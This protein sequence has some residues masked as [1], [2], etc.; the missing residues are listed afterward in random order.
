MCKNHCKNQ[1]PPNFRFFLSIKSVNS[2]QKRLPETIIPTET[3]GL[4]GTW[5]SFLGF[6]YVGP[7]GFRPLVCFFG[8]VF[9][10]SKEQ[11]LRS[12]VPGNRTRWF[13]TWKLWDLF[14]LSHDFRDAFYD[15]FFESMCIFLP[16]PENWI[17][18]S[19]LWEPQ[20][21]LPAQ[22]ACHD[23][24]KASTSRCHWEISVVVLRHV[25]WCLCLNHMLQW[26]F[27]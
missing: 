15:I 20:L 2:Q 11:C 17:R 1:H 3:P 25:L 18:K 16:S 23:D 24:E 6:G 5:I 22:G 9:S 8:P 19:K 10:S 13:Y 12:Q 26:Q 14:W 7:G 4:V 21:D 27:T